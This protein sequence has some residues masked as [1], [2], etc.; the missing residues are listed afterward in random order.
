MSQRAG[1]ICFG[2]GQKISSSIQVDAI[3]Y[4]EAREK[5]LHDTGFRQ[6]TTAW[7]CFCC[8]AWVLQT[9]GPRHEISFISLS[10][11]LLFAT[12]LLQL[13]HWNIHGS[14]ISICI[15]MGL[16]DE[17]VCLIRHTVMHVV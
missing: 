14:V 12:L 6:H 3:K 8:F 4:Q 11:V 1:R 7:C 15:G 5:S 16:K 10:A 13:A 2:Y 9:R 17:L